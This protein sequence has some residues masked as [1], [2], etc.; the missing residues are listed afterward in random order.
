MWT[1]ILCIHSYVVRYDPKG[2]I[3]KYNVAE[4]DEIEEDD[5]EE[6][7]VHA[8]SDEDVEEVQGKYVNRDNVNLD[9]PYDIDVVFDEELEKVEP[10]VEE[11]VPD[12]DI[13]NDDDVDMVNTLY[14]NFE[15][16]D[17][18]EELYEEEY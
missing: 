11:H 6:Q 8:V 16:D 15:L 4:E 1:C 14:M 18:Y 3:V 2:R 12:D 13:H 5:V 9:E 10:N 17:T 7:G